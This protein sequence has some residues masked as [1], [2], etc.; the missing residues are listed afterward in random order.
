M[1]SKTDWDIF[2][3]LAAKMAE[4]A[5]QKGLK[6][7]HDEAFDWNRDFTQLAH[8]W[9]GKGSVQTDEQAVNF[10]LGNAEETKGVNYQMIQEQRRRFVATDPESWNSPIKPGVA[11]TPFQFQADD[12]LSWRTLTGR[13][14]FYID[15]PWYIELGGDEGLSGQSGGITSRS[16]GL[17]ADN[18]WYGRP[19]HPLN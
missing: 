1:K 15:H 6:P 5:T 16:W 9:T 8:N 4:V 12:K 10:I 19:D 17:L 18:G 7:F 3:A 13:Q 11:Y 14:R 2:H